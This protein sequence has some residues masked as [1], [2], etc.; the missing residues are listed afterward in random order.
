MC[1]CVCVCVLSFS[2]ALFEMPIKPL[3]VVLEVQRRNLGWT[4]AFGHLNY[5]NDCK[6]LNGI[7]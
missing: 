4:Q 7:S 6:A 5:I 3:K 2:R 1:V